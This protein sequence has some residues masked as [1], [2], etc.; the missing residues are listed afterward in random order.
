M[1]DSIKASKQR[2]VK[3]WHH[4]HQEMPE[5]HEADAKE[6]TEHPSKVGHQGVEAV[7][8][9]LLCHLHRSRSCPECINKALAGTRN[10]DI[11]PDELVLEVNTRSSAACRLYYLLIA[12]IG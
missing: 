1:V 3:P 8:V 5:C 12:V 9:G 6:E 2:S 4:G 11:F 7:D 10:R